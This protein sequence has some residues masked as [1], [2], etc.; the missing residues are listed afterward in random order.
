MYLPQPD[1]NDRPQLQ[2][3]AD[4]LFWSTTFTTMDEIGLD[5]NL[6]VVQFDRETIWQIA[7]QAAIR[8]ISPKKDKPTIRRVIREIESYAGSEPLT[9]QAR[10]RLVTVAKSYQQVA[11]C[12]NRKRRAAE[13]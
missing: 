2:A 9:R 1:L 5:T 12:E 8:G 6:P 10:A 11:D 7:Q 4:F 13:V 3:A